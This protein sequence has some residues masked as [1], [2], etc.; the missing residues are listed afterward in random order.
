MRK[1]ILTGIAVSSALVVAILAFAQHQDS[2][3]EVNKRVIH[4]F[5]RF[6]WE[7]RDLEAFKQYT[8]EDYVE[9]NPNFAGERNNIIRVLRGREAWKSPKEVQETLQDPPELV[10]AEGDLVQW[11]FKR[12]ATDPNDPSTIYEFFW[13]DTFRV[14]DGLIVEH[15]DNAV[16]LQ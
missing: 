13:Y 6:A 3:V 12:T 11:V 15:W 4:D 8:S 1:E 16:L 2:S 10:I 9:H 7:P 5:Y 14:Q